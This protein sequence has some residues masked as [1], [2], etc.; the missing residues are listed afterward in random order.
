MKLSFQLIDKDGS[1]TLSKIRIT[2][3]AST[4]P[5]LINENGDAKWEFWILITRKHFI[6]FTTEVVLAN[7]HYKAKTPE[8]LYQYDLFSRKDCFVSCP[9]M[10]FTRL[11]K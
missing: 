3:H 6:E 9:L 8:L 10:L 11:R 7:L 5:V 1:S 4:F 2:R